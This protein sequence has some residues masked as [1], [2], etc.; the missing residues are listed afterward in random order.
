MRAR[1]QYSYAILLLLIWCCGTLTTMASEVSIIKV[2]LESIYKNAASITLASDTNI[3]IGYYDQ[4]GFTGIGTLGQSKITISKASSTYYDLG[5]IYATYQ[6][7]A[8]AAQQMMGI[9]VY[10]DQGLF[11]VYT[12]NPVG[13]V[14]AT[15]S[16]RYVVKD[17]SGQEIF[18]FN[19]SVN[20]IVFRGYDQ[21]SGLHLTTVGA[22]KKYRG[23]IGMGGTTGITPYNILSI[24]EYLYGVVPCEMSASWPQEALKAQAV[25]ARSIAIYQY[26][27]FLSSGYNVVDTTTTQAYGGYNKEDSRTTLAVDAT[28]GEMIRYNGAVAEALYFSTSGGYTESAVNVWGNPIGYL[29]GVE[30]PY[31]I[32]PAQPAWTR[33]ITLTELDKCLSNKGVNIGLAQGVQIV[34]RTDSGRVQEMNI[35]GTVGNYSLKL[36]NIRT[37]FS[38][39]NGGSLKSRL[40]TLAGSGSVDSGDSGSISNTVTVVSATGVADVALDEAIVTNGTVTQPIIGETATIQSATKVEQVALTSQDSSTGNPSGE[41]V[42][43]DVTINGKGFGHGVGMSQSGAKGMAKAGFSYIQILQHYYQGVTVG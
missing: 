40:F 3:E 6:E 43:G 42:Y 39:T 28:K 20:Q 19:Q 35:L 12:T 27:R 34:S 8:N 24:E 4:Y 37:F 10:V 41:V 32:E 15:S 17:S 26:K 1:K 13:N 30:D 11:A 33:T 18:I 22:S 16:T 23:A 14:V 29:V 2:G 21:E 7:A 38:G 25:A 5:G 31:E 36:E 9:P